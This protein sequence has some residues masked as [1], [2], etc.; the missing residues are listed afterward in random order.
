MIWMGAFVEGFEAFCW[1]SGDT[2][3]K[4]NQV[5]DKDTHREVIFHAGLEPATLGS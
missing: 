1:F 5:L 4:K 3:Q 2:F